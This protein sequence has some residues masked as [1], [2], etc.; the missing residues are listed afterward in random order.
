MYRP[1][2]LPQLALNSSYALAL[3]DMSVPPPIERASRSTSA[4]SRLA[5]IV[6][7]ALSGSSASS[8]GSYGAQGSVSSTSSLPTNVSGAA[9]AR[10]QDALEALASADQSRFR[11]PSADGRRGDKSRSRERT[12]GDPSLA[13]Y[14]TQNRM[15][16][17]GSGGAGAYWGGESLPPNASGSNFSM[18]APGGSSFGGGGAGGE[19]ASHFFPPGASAFSF[20]GGETGSYRSSA[21]SPSLF[22]QSR[23]TLAEQSSIPENTSGF[24]PS[25]S[26]AASWEPS[27]AASARARGESPIGGGKK[28]KESSRGLRFAVHT[29]SRDRSMVGLAKPPAD[30]EQGRVAVAGRTCTSVSPSLPT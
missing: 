28:M 13:A 4:F 17:S 30:G 14:I 5:G 7:S 26:L 20:E 6:P 8:G 27:S 11:N 22:G 1:T 21:G 9:P 16:A 19:N 18:F 23:F 2:R 12:A 29:A 24:M 25:G 3:V 10:A 15:V